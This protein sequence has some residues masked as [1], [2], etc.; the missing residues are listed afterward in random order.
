MKRFSAVL[1][2]IFT[3]ILKLCSDKDF[4]NYVKFHYAINKRYMFLLLHYSSI[5][6]YIV[7]PQKVFNLKKCC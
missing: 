6:L 5:F 7:M 4:F 2:P 3:K 1:Y